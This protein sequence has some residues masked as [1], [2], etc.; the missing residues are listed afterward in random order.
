MY[1]LFL[2]CGGLRPTAPLN[3]KLVERESEGETDEVR[4]DSP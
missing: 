1:S 4:E 3:E 2:F